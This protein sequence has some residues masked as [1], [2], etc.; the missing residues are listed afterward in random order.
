MRWS[1]IVR[2]YVEQA[3]GRLVESVRMMAGNLVCCVLCL[4]SRRT[5]P[6]AWL[7]DFLPK[8]SSLIRG[9][10]RCASSRQTSAIGYSVLP[11]TP[12]MTTNAFRRDSHSRGH[13]LTSRRLGLHQHLCVCVCVSVRRK[14]LP[15][16]CGRRLA[17]FFVPRKRP[18][19]V[20]ISAGHLNRIGP[21][22][23]G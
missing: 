1:P 17:R 4:V 23:K 12:R 21:N 19:W 22:Q 9:E 13:S 14:C 8:N 5:L 7:T 16:G 6:A 10:Q 3:A 20:E 15:P 2:L 11:G 18:R